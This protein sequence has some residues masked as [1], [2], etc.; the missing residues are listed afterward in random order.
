MRR[1]TSHELLDGDQGTPLEIAQSLDDLWRIN[2]WLGGVS[3]SLRLLG[4]FFKRT[5]AHPVRILDVGS[6]DAR[7][8][9]LLRR[10]L[11]RQS[12]RAEFFVL[13][14][15]FTHLEFGSPA[16]GGL[17][18]VVADVLALP[19]SE[20]SFEVVLCNLF[21]HHFSGSMAQELLRRLAAVASEAVLINDLERNLLPY[22]FIRFA[23]SFTRSRITRHDAP[24]SVRQAYTHDELA[25]LAAAAGF[26][27]FD[28]E[29]LLPFRLGLTLWKGPRN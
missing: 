10:E 18:P 26:C 14:R 20:R 16:V 28:V 23:T 15:R 13:D 1:I 22:L 6:G 5:G 25:S 11:L 3:S 21:L 29:R 12:I 17:I 8:A 7:L 9:R 4:H 24:A 27:D 19:F 2:R